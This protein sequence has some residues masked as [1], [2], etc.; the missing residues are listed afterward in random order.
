MAERK[1]KNI[2]LIMD[3]PGLSGS[4][5]YKQA[6]VKGFGIKKT[7]FY[8]M[9]RTI[10]KLP[11][12]TLE[13]KQLATPIKYRKPIKPID[14]IDD[15]P[16]PKKDGTY[17]IV[18]I[19]VGDP[20]RSFWIKYETKKSLKEQFNKLKSRYKF[21]IKEII[22]HGFGTYREFID[23]EFKNLLESVGINL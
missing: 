11:E 13:K 7:D 6:R 18:E 20:E 8:E 1:L 17:G 5:L 2:K 9:F 22:Y 16:I 14:E 21:K 12:P 3:N 23:K 15:L 10:R 19:D 4:E